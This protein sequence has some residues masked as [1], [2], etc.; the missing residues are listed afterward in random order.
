VTQSHGPA[1]LDGSVT[2]AVRS[3]HGPWVPRPARGPRLV[4]GN[5]LHSRRSRPERDTAELDALQFELSGLLVEASRLRFQL[6]RP[7]SRVYFIQ[8]YEA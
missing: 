7:N 1:V 2:S 6:S 4:A 3:G 5:A 8:V